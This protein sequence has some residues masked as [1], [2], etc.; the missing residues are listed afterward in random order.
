MRSW[1]FF[2]KS[3]SVE[4]SLDGKAWKRYGEVQNTQFATVHARQEESVTHTFTVNGNARAKF[5]KITAKNFGTLPE[6]HVSAG[7]QAWLFV[8]EIII[9]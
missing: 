3:V 9:K 5:I 4:Y 2:P 7:E 8:D 6:W 1:V